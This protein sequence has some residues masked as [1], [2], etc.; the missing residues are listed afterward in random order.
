MQAASDDVHRDECKD[1]RGHPTSLRGGCAENPRLSRSDTGR[2]RRAVAAGWAKGTGTP[3]R[4][5]KQRVLWRLLLRA[6]EP[7]ALRSC[8]HVPCTAAVRCEAYVTAQSHIARH[9]VTLFRLVLSSCSSTSYSAI[10]PFDPG[11]N[12]VLRMHGPQ[13]ACP[14]AHF[15]FLFRTPPERPRTRHG[16]ILTHSGE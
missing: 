16:P 11:G 14:V 9:R 6:G 13:Q 7:R 2:Q 4:R 3:R 5:R 10:Y 15:L 12:R 8:A 1:A